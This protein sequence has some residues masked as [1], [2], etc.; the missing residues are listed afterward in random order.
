MFRGPIALAALRTSVVLGLRLIVQAG[1]LLL[2]AR[3]LG[4]GQ[5]GSFVGVAALAVLLGTLSTFGTHLV[6]LGA[7]S[8]DPV[9][10]AQILSY[11]LPTTLL[12]GG[13]L[14]IAFVLICTQL[15]HASGVGWG[16]LLA[17]GVAEM[18]LMPLSALAVVEVLAAEHTARSQLLQTL[19][20][21][22]RLVAAAAV[23][24]LA[25]ED[26][27]TVY[28]YGY[29]MATAIGLLVMLACL[30]RRW[31][32]PRV[33]RRPSG[34]ELREAASYAALNISAIGPAELDKTLAIRL[35]PLPA[36]GLYAAAAR[37]V[38][39]V[40][41]PVIALMLSA[42]PRLFREGHEQ[43]QRTARLL[44]WIFGATALYGMGLAVALWCCAP[45]FAW[46][47]G[48]KY[49][50]VDE[51]VR[52]LCLAV[53]GMA[54]RIAAGNALMALGKPWMRAGFEVAGL[55]VLSV[56]AMLLTAYIG[57]FGMALALVCSEWAMALLGSGL[58]VR[59]CCG[60]RWRKA[61]ASS[62]Q[63]IESCHK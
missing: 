38:G 50:G 57:I 6:L 31:P 27:L 49:E 17:L 32:H 48:G 59:V 26:P 62:T 52:W 47:L 29:C 36:A 56:A 2:V 13:A 19:P 9:S 37:V 4:P 42:L 46:L 8:K 43:P 40:T 3:M 24:W 23:G 51:V 34:Q 21:A 30:P 10:R 35:L 7:M 63:Y 33:W 18:L 25:P 53:P 20:L 44:R 16:V 14:L 60:R 55:V 1:T 41:L 11:A 39:A 12:C 5:F 61:S 54:L 45:L 28:G 22:L 15:L 58:V